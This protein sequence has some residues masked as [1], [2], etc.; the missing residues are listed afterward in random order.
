[1]NQDLFEV[2]RDDYV[3]FLDQLRKDCRKVEQEKIDG[4]HIIKT[5][6]KKTN[7]LLCERAIFEETGE[8]K[9]YIYEMPEA[10]ESQPP[11]PRRKIVLE[12]QEEV[13][14]FF[15]ILAHFSKK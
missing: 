13:Q 15:D 9:F 5:F 3:S 2:T 11:R 14:K 10:E 6:S 8:E 7:K 12:T 4:S 1:M